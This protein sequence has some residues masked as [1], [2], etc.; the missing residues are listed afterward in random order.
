MDEN[1][2]NA[3]EQ[4]ELGQKYHEGDGLEKDQKKAFYWYTKAAEQ[5][6]GKA[7]F[8]LAVYHAN[9]WGGAPKDKKLAK[10]YEAK[11]VEQFTKAAEQGDADAQQ[12][13]GEAY[14]SPSF[15]GVSKDKKKAAYWYDKAYEQFA[16]AAEQG[17]AYAQYKLG[18]LHITYYNRLRGI[19][20][21]DAKVVY[22]FTK[23]AERGNADAQYGLGG[24]YQYGNRGV[25]ENKEKA[26]YW[27]TKAAEQGHAMAQDSLRRIRS[28]R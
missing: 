18:V 13:L 1:P 24:C 23:A 4:H 20:D 6:Y 17:N 25:R 15:G 12:S 8:S 27:Y 5:G 9:G 22:W 10:Q 21:D 16:R 19:Q 26:I 28:E 14:D 3:K 2:T 11:S 7:L